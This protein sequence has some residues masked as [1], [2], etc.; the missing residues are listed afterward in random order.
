MG[1]SNLA[2]VG[3]N[4]AKQAPD[5]DPRNYGYRKLGELI[6]ASGLF[7]IEKRKNTDGATA[8]TLVRRVR[9]GRRKGEDS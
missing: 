3:S 1:W 5:F 7:E 9:R 4:V 2:P 6:A 8:V